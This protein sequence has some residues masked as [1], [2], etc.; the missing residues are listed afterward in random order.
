[1]TSLFTLGST[2]LSVLKYHLKYFFKIP[3]RYQT[4]LPEFSLHTSSPLVCLFILCFICTHPH[5]F[6]Y[7]PTKNFWVSLW[8]IV[9]LNYGP[10]LF[11][12]K[13]KI[14]FYWRIIAL[15]CFVGFCCAKMGISHNYTYIPSLWGFP[16][17]PP[18]LPSRSLQSWLLLLKII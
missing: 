18:S 13:K 14:F 17:I 6:T 11:F 12:L 15:Q 8:E 9:V 7:L 4:S 10:W 3:D 16:P 2:F 5:S 1:M